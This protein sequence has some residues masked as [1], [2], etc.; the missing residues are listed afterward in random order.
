M[1]ECASVYI[2]TSPLAT[3][4]AS[5]DTVISFTQLFEAFTRAPIPPRNVN[6]SLRL[7]FIFKLYA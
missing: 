2:V 7:L 5:P 3:T 1:A 4:D 6:F